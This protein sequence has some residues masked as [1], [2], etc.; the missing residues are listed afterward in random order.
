MSLSVLTSIWRAPPC[1][2]GDLLCLLAIADNADDDGYAWPSMETIARKAALTKRGAQKCVRNLQEMGLIQ[3]KVGGGKGKTN[4]YQITTCGVGEQPEHT[5]GEHYSVNPSSPYEPPKGELSC[6]KGEQSD[7]KGEPQFTQNH[8]EQSI[9]QSIPPKSPADILCKIVSRETADDFVQH[10]KAMKKPITELAAVRIVR[11]LETHHDPEAVLDL[12][13]QNGWQGIF[14][15]QLKGD[16]SVKPSKQS[17]RV[18]AFIAGAR[19]TP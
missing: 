2:G 1:G 14:P 17:E 11:K 8:Q 3:I 9:E 10:R 12:S 16:R 13:I 18:N 7:T 5:K 15:E 4:A 19:G 6:S